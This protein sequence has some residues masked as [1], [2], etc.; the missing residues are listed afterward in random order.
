M[1]FLGLADTCILEVDGGLFELMEIE[2][3]ACFQGGLMGVWVSAG[4]WS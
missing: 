2:V 4:C 3:V 1:F